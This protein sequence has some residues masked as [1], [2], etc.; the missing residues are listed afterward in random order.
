VSA[1]DHLE[2]LVEEPSAEAALA[3]VLPK[4]LGTIT[5]Q[6]HPH[7]G[8]ADLLGKLPAKFHGYSKWLPP[9]W[10]IL[11]VVDRDDDD[12]DEL[13][14]KLEA[15]AADAG[16]ATRSAPKRS[17]YKVIN[18]IAVEELEAWF[19]GDWKAV[20]AAYPKARA[21]VPTKAGYRDS[22]A[23]AGGT[24]EALERVLQ[25]RGYFSTGLRKIE[26]ARAIAAHMLP[27]RNASPSFRALEAALSELAAA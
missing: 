12:C 21:D 17:A 4:M 14:A 25:G 11:V 5:F 13:K 22:D 3:L 2:V 27:S 10:R 24:W 18:R 19:F 8:K 23:I 15:M 7:R 1:V 20:R 26:A 16:L 9:T 6:I